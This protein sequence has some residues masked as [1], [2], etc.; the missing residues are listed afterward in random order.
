MCRGLSSWCVSS[1]PSAE[2]L[3][4]PNQLSSAL[5]LENGHSL[6]TLA[7]ESREESKTMRALTEKA[8]SDATA[9]KVL[10][11]ITLTY[12]PATAV[13]VSLLSSLTI[14]CNKT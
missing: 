7:E 11:I 8:T 14:F 2:I 5:D 3:T 12:L 10:T 1:D 9:V 6:K 4:D 13:L